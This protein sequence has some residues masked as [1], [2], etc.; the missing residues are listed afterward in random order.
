VQGFHL[1]AQVGRWIQQKPVPVVD[2]CHLGLG[3]RLGLGSPASNSSVVGHPLFHWENHRPQP[4]HLPFGLL[5]AG[6]QVDCSE[7]GYF[8]GGL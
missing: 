6:N 5:L 3:A 4:V 8:S 7:H 1:P 2:D